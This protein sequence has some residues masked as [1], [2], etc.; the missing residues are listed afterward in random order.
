MIGRNSR[1]LASIG[2]VLFVVL[3]ASLYLATQQSERRAS[4]KPQRTA[5]T[6][7]QVRPL[8]SLEDRSS[9]ISR[10]VALRRFKLLRSPSEGMPARLTAHTRNILGAF[11]RHAHLRFDT[12][13]YVSANVGGVWVLNGDNVL[14]IVQ[15]RRGA[16]GCSSVAFV[17]RQGL[18]LGV[19]KAPDRP[20]ELPR[21]FS[22]L[23]IAPNW[24]TTARL[25]IGENTIR[26]VP[27]RWNV[28]G[29]HAHKPI[30]LI[31]LEP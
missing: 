23:G 5:D 24:A 17:A 11:V 10:E 7:G 25:R 4:L 15:A 2:F 26:S 29:F 6:V 28:Y 31:R 27:I 1:R 13:Q 22:L 16:A 20:D 3:G 18:D 8:W 19:F 21:S 9:G 12:A 30:H 14:C